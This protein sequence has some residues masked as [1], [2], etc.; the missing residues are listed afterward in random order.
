MR[1]R[2][3]RRKLTHPASIRAGIGPECLERAIA[4]Q[5]T[6]ELL[7]LRAELAGRAR[8]VRAAADDDRT[9]DLFAGQ[10]PP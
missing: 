3:C 6:P 9:P 8:R 10:M 4:A 7:R 5:P 1:C 2:L